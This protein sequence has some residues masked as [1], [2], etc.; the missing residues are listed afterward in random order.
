MF[1]HLLVPLDGSDVAQR[2]LDHA[3][4]YAHSSGGEIDLIHVIDRRIVQAAPKALPLDAQKSLLEKLEEH[5]SGVLE[6]AAGTARSRGVRAHTHLVH[7]IIA[8]EVERVSTRIG[9]DLIVMG[10]HGR[11]G[12]APM[13]LGSVAESVLQRCTASVLLVRPHGAPATK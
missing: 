1:R 11:R 3:I 4:D 9:C 7:G 8:E 13:I 10:T 2:A 5:G 6:Q 12:W